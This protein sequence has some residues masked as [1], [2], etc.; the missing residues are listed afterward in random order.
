MEQSF[1]FVETIGV[2]AVAR[3]V[4]EMSLW[5]RL[6]SLDSRYG[7]VYYAE[8]L[9][10]QRRYWKDYRVQLDREI[11]LLRE[12]EDKEHNAQTRAMSNTSI[13]TDSRKLN[14][15]LLSIRNHIDNEAARRFSIYAEQ[16]KTNG[17]G[18]QAYLLEKKVVPIID[19]SLAN[20][21]S[22]QTAFYARIPQSIKVMIPANWHWRQLA[23]KVGLT[24]E[25]DFI[26]SF[27]SKLL[28]ATPLSITTDQKNLELP[29]MAVFLKYIN[30]KIVE[31][32]ELTREYQPIAT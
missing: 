4:F 7:L 2:V 9:R 11:T 15:D 10:T 14:D 5:L 18:F 21:D 24:D 23:Q 31:V 19:Q 3:Y 30:I 17:Y 6:F 1:N 32:I 22:E 20:V 13:S 16:A 25:Y 27:S 29:E 28:H 8:L 12:F 26:Y